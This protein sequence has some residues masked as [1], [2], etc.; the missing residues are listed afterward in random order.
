MV[1]DAKLAKNPYLGKDPL[2]TPPPDFNDTLLRQQSE[3]IQRVAE[4]KKKL[5]NILI[6]SGISL[7]VLSIAGMLIYKFKNK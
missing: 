3:S 1:N 6:I 2:G 7:F 4:K 5:N